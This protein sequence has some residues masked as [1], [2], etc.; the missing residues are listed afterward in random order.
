M[1]ESPKKEASQKKNPGPRNRE[2]EREE[3]NMSLFL[4]HLDHKHDMM[5]RGTC[6]SASFASW[7]RTKERNMMKHPYAIDDALG[8][9]GSAK[10]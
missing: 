10:P 5:Q 9:K 8:K 3:G 1:H 7:A 4:F 2:K 6:G